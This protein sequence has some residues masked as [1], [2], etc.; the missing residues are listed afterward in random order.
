MDVLSF[1]LSKDHMKPS[2]KSKDLSFDDIEANANKSRG[3]E[4]TNYS[5]TNCFAKVSEKE[6]NH[7]LNTVIVNINFKSKRVTDNTEDD[8][9]NRQTEPND[10]KQ[11]N[12]W[13]FLWRAIRLNASH[14]KSFRVGN[15]TS[16]LSRP[17]KLAITETI[18]HSIRVV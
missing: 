6:P 15:Q 14:L 5:E 1:A 11:L 3:K 17:L 18:L 2:F 7:R 13:T 8:L 10:L 9:C 4:S 12:T 16:T